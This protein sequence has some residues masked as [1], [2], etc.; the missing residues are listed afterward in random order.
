MI[1]FRHLQTIEQEER[2]VYLLTHFIVVTIDIQ[3]R[4]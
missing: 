3:C 2:R 1:D 4:Q